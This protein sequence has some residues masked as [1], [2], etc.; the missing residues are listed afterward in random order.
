ME[1][2]MMEKM[3]LLGLVPFVCKVGILVGLIGI[4]FAFFYI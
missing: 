1:M 3:S 4:L 2:V